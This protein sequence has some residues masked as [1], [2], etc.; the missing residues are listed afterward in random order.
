MSPASLPLNVQAREILAR[1]KSGALLKGTVRSRSMEGS[2]AVAW[3]AIRLG[4][5][6]ERQVLVK[7]EAQLQPGQQVVIRCLPDPSNPERYRFHLA[8]TP[9]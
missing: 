5:V 1:L 4:A 2:T 7:D 3:I 8:A 6:G 9:Q